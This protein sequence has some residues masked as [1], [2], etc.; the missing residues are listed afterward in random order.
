ML[1]PTSKKF[2]VLVVLLIINTAHSNNDFNTKNL[3]EEEQRIFDSIK[4]S[5]PRLSEIAPSIRSKEQEGSPERY[6]SQLRV[7]RDTNRII[8]LKMSPNDE[9]N[10]KFCYKA[11]VMIEFGETIR[12]KIER[13]EMSNRKVIDSKM[14]KGNR[15]VL[16]SMIE[17]IEKLTETEGK[18]SS[19]GGS[20]E[21]RMWV[22][23]SSDKQDYVFNLI[24]EKCPLNGK[25][26]Y[27]SKVIIEDREGNNSKDNKLLIPTDYITELTK[28]TLRDN[29]RNGFKA[30][31]MATLP[32]SIWHS[33]SVSLSFKELPINIR[34]KDENYYVKMPK[35]IVLDSNKEFEIQHKLEHL[36]YSS[37]RET[38][39]RKIPVSRYNLKLQITKKYIYEKKYIYVIVLFEDEE[40]HQFVK[41][42]V[43]DLYEQRIDKKKRG[44]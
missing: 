31:G 7:Y 18:E 39:E 15:S 12:S 40:Y 37:K 22:E 42:P 29:T 19:I 41:I 17:S 27:P 43:K 24:G 35:F 26:K 33:I 14:L 30:N 25:M 28:N 21:T 13:I 6:N 8:S 9:V 23:R 11:P 34:K 44:L 4:N 20:W 2:L 16:V 10:I 38:Q 36:N 1:N 3:T 5:D 32:N